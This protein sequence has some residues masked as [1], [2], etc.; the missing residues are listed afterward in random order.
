MYTQQHCPPQE[1]QESGRP[2]LHP[3][4]GDSRTSGLLASGASPQ[5]VNPYLL[6]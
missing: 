2:Y 1:Q 5:S 6:S 4:A 3:C